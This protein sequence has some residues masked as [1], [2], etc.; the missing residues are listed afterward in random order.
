MYQIKNQIYQD[1][2]KTQKSALC[3]FLRALVKKSPQM[4]VEDIYDKFVEDERY[5]LEINNPHFEFLEDYLDSDKFMEESILYLKEC[6]KYYDYKKK[7]EPIIQAQKEFEKKKR[8]FLKEVKMS[9]EAP[10]KKQLYYYDR[11]C[12]K[13]NIEK[14]ELTSKLE[15]RDEI[16]KILNEHDCRNISE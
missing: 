10:T 14:K 15:A 5:Y 4:S 13:Y 6:R 16:D 12:K 3:N 2:T 11:L 8:E 1:M 9:K 7:Q